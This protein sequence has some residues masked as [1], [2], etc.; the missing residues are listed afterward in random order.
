MTKWE[1]KEFPLEKSNYLS[2]IKD[3]NKLGT[4]EWELILFRD[5]KRQDGKLTGLFKRV[6]P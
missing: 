1:Y 2:M 4:D 5:V 3:L 6:K